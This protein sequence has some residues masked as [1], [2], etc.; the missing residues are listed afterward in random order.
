MQV[1]PVQGTHLIFNL[2]ILITNMRKRSQAG[3]MDQGEFLKGAT[4]NDRG[5]EGRGSLQSVN[6]ASRL[7]AFHMEAL[8]FPHLHS[9]HFNSDTPSPGLH[10]AAVIYRALLL[11][12]L[13]IDVHTHGQ[14]TFSGLIYP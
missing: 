11:H 7:L 1:F 8:A 13:K 10:R 14:Q 4:Y 3:K 5:E 9:A 2:S 12:N 6:N